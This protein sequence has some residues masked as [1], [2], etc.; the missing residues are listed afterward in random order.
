MN[1]K[2]YVVVDSLERQVIEEVQKAMA[3][4]GVSFHFSPTRNQD[5]LNQC[6]EFYATTNCKKEDF[7]CLIPQLNLYWEIGEDYYQDYGFNT[8]MFHS[9]VYFLSIEKI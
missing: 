2:A 3:S 4:L 5:T 6:T 7:D 9:H 8:K 1:L